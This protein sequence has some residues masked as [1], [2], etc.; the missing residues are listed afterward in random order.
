[1][2]DV[3]ERSGGSS[4]L[5]KMN[6]DKSRINL[7]LKLHA[8]VSQNVTIWAQNFKITKKAIMLSERY[9]WVFYPKR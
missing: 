5:K 7:G 9:I 4:R 6:D 8:H 1:M 3:G 2:E